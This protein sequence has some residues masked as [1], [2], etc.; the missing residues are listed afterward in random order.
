MWLWCIVR[1]KRKE[2]VFMFVCL[3]CYFVK[4]KSGL[5]ISKQQNSGSQMF[6][7]R[8]YGKKL[9]SISKD[10][11]HEGENIATY[12]QKTCKK[13]KGNENIDVTWDGEKKTHFKKLV[14]KKITK[15]KQN[16]LFCWCKHEWIKHLSCR[17]G[18]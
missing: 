6:T 5:N 13:A 3:C 15:K 12:N 4:K 7:K 16:I 10:N 2:Y 8:Y 1:R 18:F 17:V 9:W 14:R 11:R